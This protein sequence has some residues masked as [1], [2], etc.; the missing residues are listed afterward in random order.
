[1]D[2]LA[3][4]FNACA[5]HIGASIEYKLIRPHMGEVGLRVAG[6]PIANPRYNVYKIL[7]FRRSSDI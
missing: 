4:L 3:F 2:R 5:M 1:M 6:K 7:H